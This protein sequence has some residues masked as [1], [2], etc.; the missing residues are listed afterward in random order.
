MFFFVFQYICALH[1]LAV[2]LVVMRSTIFLDD[3][4]VLLIYCCL[5]RA[6][7]GQEDGAWTRCYEKWR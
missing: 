2:Q 1:N 5:S 7:G 3:H 6:E 4:L